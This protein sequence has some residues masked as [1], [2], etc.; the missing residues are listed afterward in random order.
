MA[1]RRTVIS[2]VIATIFIWRGWL[3]ALVGSQTA[4]ESAGLVGAGY[5]SHV[6]GLGICAIVACLMT[7]VLVLCSVSR[8]RL[9]HAGVG[10][11]ESS[12][13]IVVPTHM[14][15]TAS[16]AIVALAIAAMTALALGF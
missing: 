2:A 7:V 8:I 14:I 5:S 15:R 11:L 16:A 6:I 12:S 10:V 1:W 9:L 3:H 13:H 4:A